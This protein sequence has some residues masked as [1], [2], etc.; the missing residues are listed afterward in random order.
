MGRF[1]NPEDNELWMGRWSARLAP[2]F[3]NFA[4]LR[5]RDRFLDVGSG[6]GVLA[7]ALLAGVESK[8]RRSSRRSRWHSN[9]SMITGR[10][11]P[12]G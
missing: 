2:A 3:V 6:T 11:S 12:V 1:S 5:K 8:W 4:D 9:P 7:A 10:H